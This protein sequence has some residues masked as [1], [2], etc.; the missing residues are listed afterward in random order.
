MASTRYEIHGHTAIVTMDHPP[1]NGL[2]AEL[3]A[4]I[5]AALDRAVS[6]TAVRAVVLTGSDRAFSGGADVKEFGTPLATRA[7]DL[8]AVIDRLENSPKPVIAA[9]AG[10]CL[11]GGLELAL[12]AHW[13]VA[14]QDARIALPEVKLGLLPGAGGTQR[15]PRLV[16][17]QTA[18]QMIVSGDTVVAT[19]LADTALFEEVTDGDVVVAATALADRVVR[20]HRPLVRVRDLAVPEQPTTDVLQAARHRAASTSKGLPAPSQ[21][22]EA[23]S[24]S[25]TLPFEEAVQRE[26]DAFVALMSTTQSRALRHVFAAERVS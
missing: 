23:V 9:I 21:C 16:G 14:R 4:G 26:R 8:R 11:G 20:E 7:P 10:V 18:L 12:A 19:S 3:R 25:V 22:V 15:L 24:W 2:G 1:V 5:M 17:L 6:D 13:R